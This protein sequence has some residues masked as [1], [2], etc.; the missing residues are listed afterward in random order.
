MPCDSKSTHSLSSC[1]H[2]GISLL[3]QHVMYF[4]YPNPLGLP[5]NYSRSFEDLKNSRAREDK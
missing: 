5:S 3:T 1:H 2:G 4:E